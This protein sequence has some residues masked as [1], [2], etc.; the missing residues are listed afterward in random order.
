MKCEWS[1]CTHFKIREEAKKA[2]LEN[3]KIFYN[4]LRIHVS[5][6][7]ITREKYYNNENY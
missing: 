6:G 4:R 7:Y 1:Y 5:Y 3:V 2:V